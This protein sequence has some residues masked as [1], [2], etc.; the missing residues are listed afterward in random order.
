ML[1]IPNK[2]KNF[3]GFNET[4]IG[5]LLIAPAMICILVV[6]IFPLFQTVRLSLFDLKLQFISEAK[7]IG[8]Q[9]Y[10]DI[11]SET[12]FLAALFNTLIFTAL[13]V[14]LELC[15][16]M[17]MALLMNSTFSGVKIVKV[18]VLVPWAIPTVISAMMWAFIYNDQFGVLNAILMK[19]GLIVRNYAWLGSP[20]T[21]FGAIIF[22]DVWKTAPFMGLLLFAGLQNISPEIY[23]ASKMDGANAVRQ[24]FNITLPL[25]KPTIL[26]A[27][28]FRTL[29]A[30]RIFD[31]VYVMT[32]GGPGNTTE[33]LAVYTYKTLFRNLDFG[34]GSAMAV[35]IFLFVFLFAMLYIRIL[36]KDTFR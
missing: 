20:V 7:F 14:A 13:S 5:Y 35:I 11:F 9:N 32:G 3:F 15:L 17:V 1:T 21:A 6:A 22:T 18:A 27:L 10:L 33:T 2:K 8:L 16:G 34:R 28:I 4:R 36:D 24:F 19:L 26:V 12:R 23:E 30:F 25:L 31:L 29:E